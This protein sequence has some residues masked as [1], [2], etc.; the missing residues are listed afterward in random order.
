[1]ARRTGRKAWLKNAR[2]AVDRAL[3]QAV[4]LDGHRFSCGGPGCWGC[5]RGAVE[6]HPHEV[7]AIAPL[8]SPEAWERVL[9]ADAE[10]ILAICPLLDPTTNRCTV[11]SERPIHCRAYAVVSPREDCYPELVGTKQTRLMRR[12]LEVVIGLLPQDGAVEITLVHQL[13]QTRKEECVS[14]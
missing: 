1:M 4:L 3:R 8:V 10:G 6:A 12:P 2:R 13:Q 11:Y 14:Q 7:G 5:C 9:A